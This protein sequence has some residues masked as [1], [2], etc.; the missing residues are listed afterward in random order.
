MLKNPENLKGLT[1]NL[2]QGLFQL[3][4]R[5]QI[6]LLFLERNS[7]DSSYMLWNKFQD[8]QVR[9]ILTDHFLVKRFDSL[10]RHL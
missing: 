5:V 4:S 6:S 10:T 1:V 8:Y 7:M 9:L 2:V 3:P